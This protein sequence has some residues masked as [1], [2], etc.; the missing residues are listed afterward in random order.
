MWLLPGV[1]KVGGCES[2]SSNDPTAAFLPSLCLPKP[3][4]PP[5]PPPLTLCRVCAEI[6]AVNFDDLSLTMCTHLLPTPPPPLKCVSTC[7]AD[8]PALPLPLTVCRVCAA[9][10]A[11]DFDDVCSLRAPICLNPSLPL[12]IC[13]SIFPYPPPL[14][15]VHLPAARPLPLPLAVCR[16]CAEN[17]AVDFDDLLGLTVALLQ[18]VPSVRQMLQDVWRHVLVDEFQV[19][20]QG[21][22]GRGG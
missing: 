20:R 15:R 12:T 6:N 14:M 3:A 19:R 13:I 9:N 10:D 2:L 5:I 21:G 22:G 4:A 1:Y 11:V 17:N 7:Q 16:V 8:A 18:Q